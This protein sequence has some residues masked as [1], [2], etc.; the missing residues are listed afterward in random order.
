MEAVG[1]L[2]GGVAHD[3]N[4]LLTVVTGYSELALTTVPETNPVYAYVKEIKKA[5]E[6]AAALT[7]Q[8]LAFSRRQLLAPRVLNLSNIVSDMGTLLRRLIGEDIQLI[9]KLDPQLRPVK[10]DP[11]QVEQVIMNLA[12]NARDAMPTGGKLTIETANAAV[13][14]S[15]AKKVPEARPGA[16]AL[17][18]V[19]D[20]GCGMDDEVQAHLFEPF[21]TTKELGKGTG[22][23]LATV[24][25]IVQ[26][27]GGHVTVA[28]EPGKGSTFCIYLPQVQENTAAAQ[29]SPRPVEPT[30]GKEI[31]LLAED[32][33]AVRS[34]ARQVLQRSGYE[35]L[36]ARN[37]EE[38]LLL[39]QS[40]P[41]PIHVLVTDVV[42][43]Q[44]S[45][46][47]LA[48]Q[49][50]PSRPDMKVLYLSGYTDSIIFRRG[51]VVSGPAFLQKPFKPEELSGKVRE[52]LDR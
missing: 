2:A 14:A 17:L 46:Y 7:R 9:T 42:M 4:N 34:F 32:E 49:L 8:L 28:S 1:R 24:Y 30:R 44:L 50:C 39:G 22:L 43:P 6:R 51:L 40:H 16:Y 35:V 3:F 19:A 21:F 15:A 25:G 48:Q 37:G 5:G 12:V 45:G 38:A 10:V 33:D 13:D 47:D 18:T 31:I 23:G 27:S 52:V 36:E 41:G 20:T 11:G 29:P 26:Q